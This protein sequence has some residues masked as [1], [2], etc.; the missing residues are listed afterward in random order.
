MNSKRHSDLAVLNNKSYQN[1]TTISKQ[2]LV[3]KQWTFTTYINISASNNFNSSSLIHSPQPDGVFIPVILSKLLL[4]FTS[5]SV[6]VTR[7]LRKS[8][9][10]VLKPLSTSQS[11]TTAH[12]VYFPFKIPP[13]LISPIASNQPLPNIQSPNVKY[14][15]T[16]STQCSLGRDNNIRPSHSSV[17]LSHIETFRQQ[18]P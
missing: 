10:Q 9:L 6:K 15:D 12:P 11:L 16:H 14:Q 13:L 4:Q 18:D 8:S 7:T 3:S 1:K 5:Q 17:L 2:Q